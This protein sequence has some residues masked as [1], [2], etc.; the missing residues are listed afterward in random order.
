MKSGFKFR[1]ITNN[2]MV[3]ICLSDWYQIEYYDISY[4][5]ILIKVRD[6]VYAGY[7]LYTHPMAG[8]VKPNETL[9]KSVVVARKKGE[10]SM[11]Q[12]Q[13]AA[14]AIETFDK[15]TPM[16]VNYAEYHLHDFQ[17]ID[18][19]LLCG[20]LDVD[21]VAGLSKLNSRQP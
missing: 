12:A 16:K 5:E 3:R 19:T 8:S 4:R 18:Y 2:P 21:A 7:K 20:A 17:L 11:E 10:L 6:L 13:L 15:F 14:I 9:Y 1:I